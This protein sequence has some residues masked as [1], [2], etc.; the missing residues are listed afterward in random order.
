MKK[1]GLTKWFSER[2]VDLGRPK[3]GGGF[4]ACGRPDASEGKYPKCV[5]AARAKAM[6]AAEIKSALRRKRAAEK[7]T[8]RVGKLPI[9][10]ATKARD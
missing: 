8:A 3:K 4:E 2:W 6:T 7:S 1:S 10:V 9:M 5:P